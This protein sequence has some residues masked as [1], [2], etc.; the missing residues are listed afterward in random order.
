[1]IYTSVTRLPEEKLGLKL[2]RDKTKI[3]NNLEESFV[4]FGYEF[5]PGYWMGPS[6]K[7]IK[8]FKERVKEITKQNQTVNVEHLIKDKLNSYL[9]G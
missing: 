8:K 4:F 7:A 9:R 3:V 5:K 6:A 2:H 1:M